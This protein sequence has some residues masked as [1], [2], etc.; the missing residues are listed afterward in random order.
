[1]NSITQIQETLEEKR[2]KAASEGT[3]ARAKL[4]NDI[5]AIGWKKVK[6]LFSG[7]GDSGSIDYVQ[8]H[9]LDGTN[10]CSFEDGAS[11]P[12][13]VN[14]IKEIEDWTYTVLQGIGVDWYNNDGGQGE[15]TIDVSTVPFKFSGN[16]DQ[17]E[18]TSS[19]VWTADEVA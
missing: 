1:M 3:S 7:Y 19:T 11:S 13:E 10:F 16:I 9:R 15:L 8:I 4:A 2:Q 14:L 18:T 6:V 5:S 12:D 17:N